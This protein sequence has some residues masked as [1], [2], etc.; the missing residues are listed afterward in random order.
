MGRCDA[1]A[2]RSFARLISLRMIGGTGLGI[3]VRANLV[4]GSL[5]G[6]VTTLDVPHPQRIVDLP[7]P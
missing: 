6:F 5:S 3:G 1:V 7:L 2:A 4:S